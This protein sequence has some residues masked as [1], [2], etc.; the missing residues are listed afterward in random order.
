MCQVDF[1]DQLVTFQ[2]PFRNPGNS[3]QTKVNI[4]SLASFLPN[5]RV[6]GFGNPMINSR[7]DVL[8]D[9]LR[10]ASLPVFPGEKQIP[11]LPV[12]PCRAGRFSFPD[13]SQICNR[14]NPWTAFAF[15]RIPIP[16]AKCVQLLYIT[17]FKACLFSNPS[18]Q[19]QLKSA[20]ARRIERTKRDSV[21]GFCSRCFVGT[22]DF[23]RQRTISA[24]DGKD[25]RRFF[26]NCHDHCIEADYDRRIQGIFSSF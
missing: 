10:S 14:N 8:F 5:S 11:F 18:A 20:I 15:G 12:S 23:R 9:Y 1:V 19:S 3:V 26:G 17:Q 25:S 13:Q 21:Q 24:L 6:R 4:A 16:V 7:C 2:H 22:V